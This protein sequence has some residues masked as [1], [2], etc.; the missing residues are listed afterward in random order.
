MEKIKVGIIGCGNISGIYIENIRKSQF[1]Q[2]VALS[3]IDRRKAVQKAEG[4]SEVKVLSPEEALE[5]DEIEV[6][7]NLTVPQ[8]HYEVSEAALK[9]GKHVYVEKP[10]ALRK[11]EGLK[12]LELAEKAGVL[13]GGAPDTFLGAGLQT[14]RKLIRDGWIGTPV[15]ATAFMMASGPESWHPEPHF[16]YKEGAGPLFDMGPYYLT[17]FVHLLGPIQ[18]VIASTRISYPERMIRSQLHYGEMIHVETPTHIS[19]NL[20]FLSGAV[21]TLITSFDVMRHGLT[22]MEIYG[23][24]GT[25][26]A[27]DPNTFGGPVLLFTPGSH[28]FMEI[29]LTGGPAHNARG[30]GLERMARAIRT[31]E[32]HPA[33][34]HLMLHVLDAMESI[35][36]SGREGKRIDLDPRGLGKGQEIS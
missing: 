17:A 26:R 14:S 16:F 3:D 8:A 12:L 27:P 30:I 15:A 10:L 35:L 29:P 33:N 22:H 1:L 11:E 19:A 7:V 25:L 20:E 4:N 9:A 2:L 23:S 28:D 18:S 31:G 32:K 5:D 21:A 6:I 36:K 34:G 24:E 13:I